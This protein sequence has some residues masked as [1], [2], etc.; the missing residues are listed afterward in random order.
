MAW[1]NSITIDK[2]AAWQEVHVSTSA[3]RPHGWGWLA[4]LALRLC[5]L[6]ALL[7]VLLGTFVGVNWLLSVSLLPA[8]WAYSAGLPWLALAAVIAVAG[9]YGAWFWWAA[10]SFDVR[11]VSPLRR[12]WR[13]RRY[14]YRWADLMVAGGLTVKDRRRRQL[15][16]RLARVRQGRFADVLK[17]RLPAGVTADRFAE[18]LPE[19][20]EVLRAREAR[21]LPAPRR[22]LPNWL[23]AR[24]P[25]EFAAPDRKPG[26]VFLRLA[27]GD[28]LV[29]VVTGATDIPAAEVDLSAVRIG[30]RD[31]GADWQVSLLGTHVLLAGATGAGKG[32]VLWSL[33]AGIGPAIRD[34]LV[35]VVGID[36][37]GGMELGFGRELFRALLTMDGAGAEDE[38]VSF[39]EELADEAD[40]RASQLAGHTRLLEPSRNLPFLLIVVDELASVTAFIADSKK[41]QRAEVA[42]GR[43]LTKGRA[44]GM[45]VVAA[46]QDPRKEIV[47][48][49][50]LFP[51]RIA[52]RLVEAGQTELVL[53][54][55]AR[56]RGAR[57]ERISETA[58]GVG[59]VV[60]DGS[61]AVTRVRAAYLAD[62][63]IRALAQTYRPG[64]VLHSVEGGIA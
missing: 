39:L 64:P 7:V 3:A 48:W 40:R 24:L 13:R 2:N 44:P 53:R 55:G 37:K 61:Q 25:A 43:L 34:G 58:P 63:D 4:W 51:T 41:R 15:A 57:C 11:I 17:V 21:V 22:R 23:A 49:R 19:I 32:S 6:L 46:L 12:W 56:E 38:A 8:L 59:Y 35:Q 29:R 14:A 18:R 50:D 60:E 16:P 20:T 28:P 33:L 47:K 36:P 31:D 45:C 1:G 52:L 27:F 10:E 26:V 9:G 62:D 42:L 30:R 54:D 5:G